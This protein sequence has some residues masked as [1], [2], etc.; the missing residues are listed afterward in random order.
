MNINNLKGIYQAAY[1]DGL[2]DTIA[3]ENPYDFFDEY[4]KHYNYCIGFQA[5]RHE[6]K[7]TYCM[8][9]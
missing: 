8:I 5:G 1:L 9:F 7:L 2:S 3:Y 6:L 4:E